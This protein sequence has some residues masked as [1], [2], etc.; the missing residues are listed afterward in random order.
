MRIGW[1]D[2]QKKLKERFFEF[3][4]EQLA[5]GSSDRD[6]NGSFDREVWQSLADRGFWRTHVPTRY[7][8]DGGD[9]WDFVAAFE[10]LAGGAGDIGFVL[11]CAAHAGLLQLLLDHGTDAQRRELLPRLTGGQVGS[12][13]A[14]EP[15]GGSHVAA[16]RTTARPA[17]T[18]GFVLSGWKSHI[19]NAPVADLAMIVGR[20]AGVGR[21]DITLFLVDREQA[22][23]AWGDHEDLLGLRT[24]PLGPITLT[25]VH[26]SADRLIGPVGGGLERLYWCLAF[27]RLIYGIVVAGHLEALL[28]MALDRIRHRESFGSPLAEHQYIQQKVVDM[29]V[30]I[31]TSRALSYTAL[32]ALIR[33]DPNV[34]TLASVAKLCSADGIVRSGLELVQIFGHLGCERRLPVER[35]LRDA[36]AF[37]IAGGTDEMQKKNIF[38][39]LMTEHSRTE[40]QHVPS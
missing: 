28:P 12:T 1:S 11:S 37:R 23:T 14:T 2:D 40:G 26:V 8:G 10:G 17:P 36:I 7:G 6:R 33:R 18:G 9:L 5:P 24:S 22:G 21:R 20:V 25:D 3:G 31:E 15:T 13:A 27:D 30:A 38:K 35:Q 4:R 39:Q 32:D 34:S 29:K 16:I 19:T